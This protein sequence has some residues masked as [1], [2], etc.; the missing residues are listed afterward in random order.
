MHSIEIGEEQTPKKYHQKSFEIIAIE[1]QN[2][3]YAAATAEFAKKGYS[4]AN[5][6]DIARNAQI[7]IGS[8]Y[9]YFLSK[10]DLFLSIVDNAY[11]ILEKIIKKIDNRSGDIFDK[12]ENVVRAAQ[13]FAKEYPEFNQIYLCIASEELAHLSAKL[14]RKVEKI[15]A[16]YYRSLIKAAQKQN[17]LD[18]DL[19]EGVVAFCID[20]L[21]LLLQY[22]YTTAYFKERMSIFLGQTGHDDDERIILGTMR[23]LRG[24]LAAKS[25]ELPQG[26]ERNVHIV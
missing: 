13:C 2:R 26:E 12:L 25:R 11:S 4:A 17:L 5:I 21:I 7:S 20:N 15:T 23:F 18:P 9:K 19:D 8:L 14:S 24:A 1:K 16:D 3:V 22:S 6:N 10:E